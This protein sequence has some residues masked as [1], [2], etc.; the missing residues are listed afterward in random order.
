MKAQLILEDGAQPK[1]CRALNVPYAVKSYFEKE[2]E[3]LQEEGIISPIEYSPWASGVVSVAK[4]DTKDMCVSGVITRWQST[5]LSEK[6]SS[7]SHVSRTFSRRWQ[8]ASY[9]VS[10]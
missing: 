10:L 2:L 5:Q 1:F 6:L 8:V 4:R 3:R 9:S 7:L